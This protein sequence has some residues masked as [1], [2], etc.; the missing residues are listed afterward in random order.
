MRL[1]MA[2]VRTMTDAKITALR[3]TRRR[4]GL[5]AEMLAQRAGVSVGW[6]F[7]CERA[8]GLMSPELAARLAA[9]L[10]VDPRSLMAPT[11][12]ARGVA[13]RFF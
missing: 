4:A 6:L 12:R 2:E 1:E 10:G 13:P 8:P 11:L 5:T 3:E 9:A 7:T